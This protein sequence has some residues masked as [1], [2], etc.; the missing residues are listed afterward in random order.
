MHKLDHAV[1]KSVWDLKD[2]VESCWSVKSANFSKK[3]ERERE[4]A[5]SVSINSDRLSHSWIILHSQC[6]QSESN[7]RQ[8]AF[9]SYVYIYHL[10]LYRCIIHISFYFINIA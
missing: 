7:Y 6:A 5:A 9:Y 4:R 3:R 8:S 2:S 1:F 10:I